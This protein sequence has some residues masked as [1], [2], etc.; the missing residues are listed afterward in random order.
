M[1]DRA[2]GFYAYILFVLVPGVFFVTGFV[3]C[4]RLL[5]SASCGLPGYLLGTV[6]FLILTFLLL[7][8]LGMFY[9][10]RESL[11][12]WMP[13]LPEKTARFLR[14][15]AP[16]HLMQ[17]WFVGILLFWGCSKVLHYLELTQGSAAEPRLG[18]PAA[19]HSGAGAGP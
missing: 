14:D 16:G 19:D 11:P 8:L 12:R 6:L 1:S 4:Y 7:Y 2:T 10:L 18:Q 9:A 13:R 5:F 15:Y 17:L 3:V